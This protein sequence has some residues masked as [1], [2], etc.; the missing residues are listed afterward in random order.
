[1]TISIDVVSDIVLSI[2]TIIISIIA[3]RTGYKANRTTIESS[4]FNMINNSKSILDKML[5]E[6][7]NGEMKDFSPLIEDYLITLNYACSLYYDKK[8]NRKRFRILYSQDI[9]TL[10]S[11]E[12]FQKILNKNPND[13]TFLR[14]IHVTITE[15]HS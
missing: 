1:M 9:L 14:R 8:I 13:F 12:S 4:A 2:V 6:T 10:F 15:L 3:W 5:V 11:A 7:P